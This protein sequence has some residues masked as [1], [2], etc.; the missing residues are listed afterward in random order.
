MR[1][2]RLDLTRYGKFTDRSLDFGARPDGGADFHIIYG[3]N[4]AGKSTT[5]QGWL[6][7]LYG[8]PVQSRMDFLHAYGAMRLGVCIEA[9]D[10]TPHDLIRTKGRAGTLTD[11]AGNPLPEAVVQGL[12]GGIDRAG[13]EAMF[14]LDDDT[15]EKGGESI[16]SSQGDLG[17][18]LFTASSGLA[19]MG[20]A[21]DRLRTRAQGFFRPGARSGGLSDMKKELADLDQRILTLDTGARDY[22]VLVQERDAALTAW[23]AAEAEQDH[24][25]RRLHQVERLLAALPLATRL[26][27]LDADLADLPDLPPLPAGWAAEL[28]GLLRE[29]GQ[30]VVRIEE[31][32]RQIAAW[33]EELTATVEDPDMLAQAEAMQAAET[34]KSDRDGAVRDLPNRRA[35][36]AAF[37]GQID[38]LL[39]QLGCAGRDPA[40]L[41]LAAPLVARLR[42][43]ME[44]HSGVA[45]AL[46]SAGAEV[47]AATIRLSELSAEVGGDG[48]A[49]ADLAL[50]DPV[51]KEQL[52]RAPEADLERAQAAHRAAQDRAGAAMARLAPWSGNGAALSALVLPAPDVLQ[53][54]KQDL[55]ELRLGIARCRA[56]IEQVD[57]EAAR[58]A[59]AADALAEPGQPSIEGAAVLRATRERL[60]SEHRATLTAESAERF[61][62][63]LRE[64]DQV[65][66][67]L[68]RAQAAAQQQA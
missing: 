39:R 9:D 10:G 14:S 26:R 47:R 46:E 64:D 20:Q 60:W 58:I 31:Q 29:H 28:P 34:L 30:T 16:L 1:L 19:E 43:L 33:R 52:R 27:L 12:L 54:W 63:A 6:D 55:S 15:L 32:D 7:L 36:A 41:V 44:R 42:A 3:P 13:Y 18:M 51:V 23:E 40:D 21:L 24:T 37:Q 68:A 4:E 25:Q 56:G 53:A 57:D 62:K 22:A 66:A 65:T 35:E 11:P 2:R 48:P 50:L 67:A 49:E 8:I 45:A 61:E 17:Q 5:M 38:D 59:V